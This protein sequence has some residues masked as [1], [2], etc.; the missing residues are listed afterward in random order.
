MW[1]P[2]RQIFVAGTC[3]CST[4]FSGNHPHM[5][6]HLESRFKVFRDIEIEAG[7]VRYSTAVESESQPEVASYWDLYT[8]LRRVG[9]FS[10][11]PGFRF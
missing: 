3:L 2:R 7:A 1:E 8:A 6:A 5:V 10:H 11:L 4:L 9:G